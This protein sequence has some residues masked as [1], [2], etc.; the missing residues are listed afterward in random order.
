M[1]SG[2]KKSLPT[3][4]G[5]RHRV[6]GELLKAQKLSQKDIDLWYEH[7]EWAQDYLSNLRLPKNEKVRNLK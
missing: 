2:P 7:N 5:W 6:S 4:R 1:L 3:P